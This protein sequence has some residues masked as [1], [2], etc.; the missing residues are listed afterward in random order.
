MKTEKSAETKRETP[1]ATRV[2]QPSLVKN[3]T[4]NSQPFFEP[5]FSLILSNLEIY[6]GTEITGGVSLDKPF[7]VCGITANFFVEVW[8][9]QNG[10]RKQLQETWFFS[11]LPPRCTPQEFIKEILDSEDKALSAESKKRE[12]ERHV[13][14]PK[15]VVRLEKD[16]TIEPW[17]NARQSTL[18]LLKEEYSL[19]A[20]ALDAQKSTAETS[21]AFIADCVRLTGCTDVEVNLNDPK[22]MALLSEAY[23]AHDRRAVRKSKVDAADWFLANPRNWS[24]LHTLTMAEIASRVKVATEIELSPGAVEKRI[25]RLGLI[26]PRKRGKP[27]QK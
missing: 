22:F 16:M 11:Q 8:W 4:Q 13:N 15:Y 12:A 26:T 23:Q 6:D 7:E 18:A 19:L 14:F 24:Q 20:S 5:N 25:E 27:A 1:I 21:K 9:L 17:E 10:K 3:T 2:L